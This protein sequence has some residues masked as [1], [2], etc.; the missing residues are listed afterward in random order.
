MRTTVDIP[1]EMFRTVKVMAAEQ[2]STVR[3]LILEGL[4]MVMRTRKAARVGLGSREIQ[5]AEPET[6]EAGQESSDELIGF[7]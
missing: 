6:L 4:E 2:G 5:A 7:P 1:D 3:G